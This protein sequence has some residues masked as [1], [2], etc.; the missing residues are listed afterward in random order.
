LTFTGGSILDGHAVVIYPFVPWLAI[1]IFGWL[2]G[3][4][5]IAMPERASPSRRWSS[6]SP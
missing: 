1:M 4:W 2:L 3:R 6:A 5:G